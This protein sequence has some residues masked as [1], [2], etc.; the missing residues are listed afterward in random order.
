M[1]NMLP[2]ISEGPTIWYN[3]AKGKKCRSL[4]GYFENSLFLGKPI[5]DQ[6][7]E[8]DQGTSQF[9]VGTRDAQNA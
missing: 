7:Y 5:Q 6:G 8:S 2:I 4:K 1:S 3:P 9:R